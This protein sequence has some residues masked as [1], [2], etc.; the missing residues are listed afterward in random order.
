[1][2]SPPAQANT[3]A[4]KQMAVAQNTFSAAGSATLT[5]TL[6]GGATGRP[7]WVRASGSVAGYVTVNIGTQAQIVV[8]VTPNAPYTEEKI[9]AAAFPNPVGA[10]PVSATAAGAGV[11]TVY[12]GFA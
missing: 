7:I 2:F 4:A 12:I 3:N 10:V 9:P 1:M 5:P 8:S 11:I 6:P